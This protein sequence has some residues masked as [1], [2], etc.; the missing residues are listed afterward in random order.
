[1]NK[2]P[3]I[4]GKIY[5][6]LGIIDIN[7]INNWKE[8]VKGKSIWINTTLEE[9]KERNSRKHICVLFTTSSLNEL[10]SINLIDDSNKQIEFGNNEKKS[11]YLKLENYVFIQ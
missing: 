11:E 1:M 9:Q 4:N 3:L 5:G 10:L 6:L 8:G 7:K 2:K